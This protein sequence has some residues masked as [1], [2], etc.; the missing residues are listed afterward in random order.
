[1]SLEIKN[2]PVISVKQMDLLE[3]LMIEEFGI[4]LNEIMEKTGVKLAEFS[5]LLL[6]SMPEAKSVAILAAN[7]KG[8]IAGMTAARYLRDWGFQVNVIS[9]GSNPT[10]FSGSDQNN[11]KESDSTVKKSDD[12]LQELYNNTFDLIVDA[13]MVKDTSTEYSGKFIEI[14]DAINQSG[15]PVIS[16]DIPSGL[17]GTTGEPS[18]HCIRALATL[19]LALPKAS[20]LLPHARPYVGNLYLADISVPHSLYEKL[21]IPFTPIFQNESIISLNENSIQESFHVIS[22]DQISNQ[23]CILLE[24]Y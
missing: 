24:K 14:F 23:V 12:A 7:Y 16:L 8:T 4:Q 13:L 11:F 1:M 15:I 6:R 17:N 19:C 5:Q 18:K 3:Q 21:G 22:A 9:V 2:I 10:N 20:L